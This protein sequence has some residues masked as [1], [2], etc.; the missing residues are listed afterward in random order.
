M[1]LCRFFECRYIVVHGLKLAYY[2]GSEELEWRETARFIDSIAPFA[3]EMGITICIENLYE[4]IGGILSKV[5][6]VT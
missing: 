1:E 2:L 5:P 3:K 6:A 4:G